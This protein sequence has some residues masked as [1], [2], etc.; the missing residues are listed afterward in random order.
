MECFLHKTLDIC[1][2]VLKYLDDLKVKINITKLDIGV[3]V[4]ASNLRIGAMRQE[5]IHEFEASLP[6]EV[7]KPKGGKI[8][9]HA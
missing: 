4:H 3:V 1:I 6:Y 5:D 7:R 2:N 9:K 8:N